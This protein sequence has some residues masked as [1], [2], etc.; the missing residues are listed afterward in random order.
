MLVQGCLE[1]VLENPFEPHSWTPF[2]G[3]TAGIIFGQCALASV[4]VD[5]E[6]SLAV[7]S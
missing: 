6:A 5:G 7:L 4:C 3:C 2:S 1:G